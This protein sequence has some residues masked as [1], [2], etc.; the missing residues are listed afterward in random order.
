MVT[1]LERITERLRQDER[2]EYISTVLVIDDDEN[3]R[4]I[5][6]RH[7]EKEGFNI[8]LASNGMDGLRAARENKPDVITLDVMMP[9]MDGWTVLRNLKQ[10]DELADIPV[11]MISM[12]NQAQAGYALGAAEYMQKPV[13]RNNL[14]GLIKKWVRRKGRA[15]VLVVDDDWDIR[16]A[17][18]T[19]LESQGHKVLEAKN[20]LEGL[21][22]IAET[23][24]S[25]IFL[26]MMMPVMNG[27]E[28]MQEL[29]AVPEGANI[30]VVAFTGV[31]MD[32]QETSAVRANFTDVIRKG[33]FNLQGLMQEV[34]RLMDKHS[35]AGKN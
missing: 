7:L 19:I 35:L 13:E 16:T 9:E 11:I 28:F 29:N 31:E 12:V 20:G 8:I 23:M 14:N 10:D 1:S 6:S 32:E 18:R 4:E 27:M 5:I 34:S 22:K 15:P 33:D 24:P 3:V 17:M 26:D 30:P 21:Q 2:R 25:M